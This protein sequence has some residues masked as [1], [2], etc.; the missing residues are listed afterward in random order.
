VFANELAVGAADGVAKFTRLRGVYMPYGSL[1]SKQ[2]STRYWTVDVT[3]RSLDSYLAQQGWPRL[4]FVKVDVEGAEEQVVRGMREAVF[5]F[6][7]LLLVELHD[8]PPHD[9]EQAR[10]V[11]PL[12]FELGYQVFSL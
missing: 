3:L 11:L 7:P 5:Q 4:S 9:R 12:L 8:G 10:K 6:S 2:D 1:L